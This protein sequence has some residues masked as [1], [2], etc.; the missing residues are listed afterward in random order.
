MR[1]IIYVMQ[2]FNI[3]QFL[4]ALLIQLQKLVN[5]E[6]LHHFCDVIAEMNHH[7]LM[8]AFYLV[9]IFRLDGLLKHLKNLELSP[10]FLILKIISELV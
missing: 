1:I 7:F 6:P 10:S 4:S 8:M 5:F 2:T 3:A 9:C